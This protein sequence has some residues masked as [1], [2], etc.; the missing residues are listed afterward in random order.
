MKETIIF[1]F[2]V[3]LVGINS[4]SNPT[5]P[6]P[7]TKEQQK[8]IKLKLVDLS[9]TEA[10]IN[11]IASDTVLPV[12]ITLSKD[13]KALFNF[14]LTK[15]DTTVIDTTLQPGKIYIY[16][17]NETIKGETENSDTLQ[18]KTL[19][20]TSSN[21]TWQTFTF[22]DA[23]TG[24]SELYDV[25]IISEDDIWC[26][27]EINVSDSSENGYT[28]Y[29]AIHWNS[30][31]WELKKIQFYTF[32]GQSS[33][34][35]YPAKAIFALS[36]SIIIV[37]SASQLAYINGEKQIKTECIP[38][39][40]SINKIW[41]TSDN[42][43]YVVGNSGSIGHYYNGQWSK[44]E[45]GTTADIGDIYGAS[46]PVM[47][48]FKILA[49]AT[50]INKYQILTLSSSSAKDT[51]NWQPNKGLSGIWF[52]ERSTYAGGTDIWINKNNSWQQVTST[53]YF[54]TR[55]KGTLCNNIYGIGPDGTVHF[56]G[57]IWQIIKPRPEGL[58]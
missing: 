19:D 41:G 56:N 22:G 49:T 5:S 52:D 48:V 38:L 23:S 34:S 1:I 55:V 8:A 16:Q 43:F 47:G 12:N 36:D 4:C 13:E 29:N 26:V 21:F 33:T 6:P 17:T 14:T 27:G 25:A 10:Y 45:S 20:T 40:I 42:D 9:C 35:S 2:I 31:K 50:A 51:L 58:V 37:G 24:S 44:I 3:I 57:S 30:S 39:T 15:T 54:F 18:V 11:V 32:C 53:G 28:T 46:E 7:P